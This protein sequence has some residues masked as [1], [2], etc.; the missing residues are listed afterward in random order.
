M[1]CLEK[2]IPS[3][4]LATPVCLCAKQGTEDVLTCLFCLLR[5]HL[6]S[7]SI[8]CIH[9]VVYSSTQLPLHFQHNPKWTYT[10]PDGSAIG[11]GMVASS[12]IITNSGVRHSPVISSASSSTRYT[13]M[14]VPAPQQ[15]KI[16]WPY[17]HLIS[18]FTQW[19]TD[20]FQLKVDQTKELIICT[21]HIHHLG[22]FTPSSATGQSLSVPWTHYR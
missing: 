22:W 20:N 14:S 19:C 17:Y 4:H 7:P 2:L 1:K 18:H 8:L 11:I 15:L 9:W 12:T 5:L 16:L 21:L 6:E 10:S 3:H 13:P